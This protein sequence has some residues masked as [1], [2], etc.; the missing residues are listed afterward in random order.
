[1]VA[2]AGIGRVSPFT[3]GT[4]EIWDQI[5]AINARGVFL[6]YKYAAKV[7]IAQGRGGRIIGA[8]SVL[9]KQGVGYVSAYTA[10]KF[11]VRGLTQS[12][13]QELAKYR[14]TV[15]AYAPASALDL[16]EAAKKVLMDS[17]IKKTLVGRLGKPEGIASIVSYLAS[18]ESAF[19]TGQTI[20]VNGGQFFD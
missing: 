18:Q 9:G 8:S 4:E 19:I 5:M 20:S 16:D 13:A 6:C 14:I 1:M 3:E 10:S 2:N 7:M 17:E 15:N 11:A 12:A